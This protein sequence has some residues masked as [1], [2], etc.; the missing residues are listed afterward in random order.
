MS[1]PDNADDI[2]LLDGIDLTP[3]DDDEDLS[4]LDRGNTVND[5]D[6]TG[7]G[8]ANDAAADKD[9]AGKGGKEAGKDGA[10]A[11]KKGKGEGEGGEEEEEE[12]D[13]ADD[14]GDDDGEGEG[15]GDGAGDG[16]GEG[17]DKSVPA[18][19]KRAQRQRAEALARAEA[20]ERE[21]AAFKSGQRSTAPKK[22][23]GPTEADTIMT[24]L[25]ALYEQVEELRLDGKTKDAAKIQRDIDAKN[26]RLG[27]IESEVQAS[28]REAAAHEDRTYNGY[29]DRLEAEFPE[30]QADHDDY[31]QAKVNRLLRMIDKGVRAGDMPSVA[32]REAAD[33][34]LG[35]DVTKPIKKKPAK[36]EK[37]AKPKEDDNAALVAARRKKAEAAVK[38]PADT[39]KRG[40]DGGDNTEVD[41]NR[42]SDDDFE[43]LPKS[44]LA[45]M[46]G[47][48]LA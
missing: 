29:L 2:S 12:E 16:D 18:R 34:V 17:P 23:D 4:K 33:L 42:L 47:D 10:D 28:K 36:E 5:D 30:L 38:Q 9:K 11:G 32:L 35:V 46:R 19:V 20:A 26:R 27:L 41:I 3:D 7:A 48:N 22:D 24:E 44:V 39:S 15:D 43:K 25:E 6:T 14:E 13:D 40:S 21:L 37:P 1:M 45:K 31:D 8:A